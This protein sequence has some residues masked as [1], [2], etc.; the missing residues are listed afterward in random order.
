MALWSD[1]GC[2]KIDGFE[3]RGRVTLTP[4]VIKSKGAKRHG[5]LLDKLVDKALPAV[6]L[7][8]PLPP[9]RRNCGPYH[10]KL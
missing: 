8:L 6:A 4:S 2:G 1:G 9:S 10:T 3:R 5:K 7:A